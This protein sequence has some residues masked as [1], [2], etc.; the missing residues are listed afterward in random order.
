MRRLT[1]N[2]YRWV[3][4]DLVLINPAIPLEIFLPPWDF[5]HVHFVGN[6]D[7]AGLNTGTFFLH[8]HAW[9]V[10]A[11]TKAMA[12]PMYRPDVD[13]GVSSDQSAMAYVF[14]ES[15]FAAG[16]LYQ[17]R[18]WYNT[19]EWRHAYEGT[20]GNLLV[21]FPGLDDERWPHMD[22]WLDV[23]ERQP[24]AWEMPLERTFYP[25]ETSAYWAALR[26]ARQTLTEAERLGEDREW[27]VS[28][29]IREGIERLRAVLTYETDNVG[30]VRETT[31]ALQLFLDK[32]APAVT[33]GE[34]RPP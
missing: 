24:R 9:S 34:H 18:V 22:K 13:L 3:D 15:A 19:Y 23:V 7:H 21:H 33:D 2:N 11:L 32:E 29:W 6:K 4:A 17:P 26:E 5:S 10:A 25:N 27:Q 20:R 1:S 31:K 28:E 14:N 12:F 8:I 16:V 30:T